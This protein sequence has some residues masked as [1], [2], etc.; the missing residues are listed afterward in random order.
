VRH[1]NVAAIT[2][3]RF[4]FS[5]LVHVGRLSFLGLRPIRSFSAPEFNP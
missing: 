3:I 1:G 2:H 5:G 4:L